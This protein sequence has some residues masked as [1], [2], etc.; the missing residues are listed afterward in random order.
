VITRIKDYIQKI[1]ERAKTID[2]VGGTNIIM[3]RDTNKHQIRIALYNFATQEII[4]YIWATNYK[5]NTT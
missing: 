3:V 2:D 4:G 1:L 5:T